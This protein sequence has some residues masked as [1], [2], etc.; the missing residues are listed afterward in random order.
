MG[1]CHNKFEEVVVSTVGPIVGEVVHQVAVIQVAP[2][3]RDFGLE[4]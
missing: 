4:L 3:V 1:L 2:V